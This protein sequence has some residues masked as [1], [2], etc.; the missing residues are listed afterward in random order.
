MS[1][2]HR[3]TVVESNPDFNHVLDGVPYLVIKNAKQKG[4]SAESVPKPIYIQFQ[5]KPLQEASTYLQPI[6]ELVPELEAIQTILGDG[7]ALSTDLLDEAV[8]KYAQT[9]FVLHATPATE[10]TSGKVKRE[11]KRKVQ[12]TSVT[13]LLG[14]QLPEETAQ[15]LD[16]A[17]SRVVEL[18]YGIDKKIVT[19]NNENEALEFLRTNAVKNE[20]GT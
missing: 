6:R 9:N 11:L 20:D 3:T 19:F 13:D 10:T 14:I 8:K 18:T 2:K 4:A 17:F 1:K 16:T 7:Y 5:P 15:R 12:F